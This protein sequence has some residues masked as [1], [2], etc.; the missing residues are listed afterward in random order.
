MV[1]KTA[2]GKCE[3][4]DVCVWSVRA[5]GGRD[6]RAARN[7]LL[8]RWR[9]FVGRR[10]RRRGEGGPA[11]ATGPLGGRTGHTRVGTLA[12]LASLEWRE[13]AAQDREVVG[14]PSTLVWPQRVHSSAW[15]RPING[16]ERN[17][18]GW[19]GRRRT[20]WAGVIEQARPTHSPLSDLATSRLLDGR[21]P[22]TPHQAKRPGGCNFGH[23][24]VRQHSAR[25]NRRHR[26]LV[27]RPG[28]TGSSSRFSQ[29]RPQARQRGDSARHRQLREIERR[30][31][32]RTTGKP[33]IVHRG[34]V[35]SCAVA[36][37]IGT[38][39]PLALGSPSSA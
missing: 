36:Q 39:W 15:Q 11:W 21:S 25:S 4:A 30:R 8:A 6:K 10:R 33:A 22:A 35:Y 19:D 23:G 17:E 27:V 29:T 31:E 5:E 32:R 9:L 37:D 20:V 24:A 7:G 3:E 28:P 13:D 2:V 34:R 14:R 16:G 38:S 18:D 12:R 1:R 26:V